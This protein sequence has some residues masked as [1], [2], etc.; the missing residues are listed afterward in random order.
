[1]KENENEEQLKENKEQEPKIQIIEDNNIQSGDNNHLE[2]LD[3]L[4]NP[5]SGPYLKTVRTLLTEEPKY[6]EGYDDKIILQVEEKES[7]TPRI[8][9]NIKN[10]VLVFCLLYSSFMNYNFLYFPYI[11]LGFALSACLYKKKK[12][13][14]T[15]L[16]LKLNKMTK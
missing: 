2:S 7:S 3:T 4:I 12:M 10:N 1:M 16:L 6:K 5:D 14:F 8:I 15:N 9:F 11:I 13:K